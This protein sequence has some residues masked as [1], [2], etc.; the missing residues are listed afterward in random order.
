MEA[1]GEKL[2]QRAVQALV[3]RGSFSD[4]GLAIKSYEK[5][6]EATAPEWVEDIVGHAVRSAWAKCE[7]EQRATAANF[8]I[9]VRGAEAK[10]A[11]AQEELLAIAA[12]AEE[13]AKGDAETIAELRKALANSEKV[14]ATIAEVRNEHAVSLL[15]ENSRLRERL[16]EA[17]ELVKSQLIRIGTLEGRLE[18]LAKKP[19]SRSPTRRKNGD[20]RK[21]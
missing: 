17:E 19:T 11:T 10:V 15:D 9:T 20:L 2:T 12:Q 7:E 18:Q 3:G 21:Q 13:R 5:A 14:I 16:R 4:L 1:K 6:K 8:L